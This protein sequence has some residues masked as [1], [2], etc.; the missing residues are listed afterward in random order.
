VTAPPQDLNAEESVLGAMLI[1]PGALGVV[2]EI[3]V[4]D[5]FYRHEHGAI[6][7]ACLELDGLGRPVDAL[8]VADYMDQCGTLDRGGGRARLHELAALVPA[9]ANAGHY[10]G[11]VREMATLRGLVRAGTEITRLGQ[12]RPGETIE[13]V[14]RAERI[15]AGV[16]R[17]S[18][19]EPEEMGPI[20]GRVWERAQEVAASGGRMV[21]IPSGFPDLDHLTLG[22][23]PGNLIVIAGRPSMGKSA[24]ALA[25]SS[26][27]ALHESTPTVVFSLEMSKL[28]LGQRLLCMEARI[29]SQ[30]LA[31]G[32]LNDGGWRRLSDASAVFGHAPLFIDDTC[33][34]VAEMRAKSRALARKAQ[35]GLIVVDYM[36][37]M[38]AGGTH[39]NRVQQISEISRSLKILAR[40]LGVPVIAL[41]QLSRAVEQR[42]DKRPML[43]DLRE[44]GSIEQDA[45][46]VIMVYRDE[47]YDPDSEHAGTAELILSKNRNGPTDT[48]RV[49]FVKRYAAFSPLQRTVVRPPS[50]AVLTG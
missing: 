24:L 27:N 34:A 28:E 14:E 21:G 11:I 9:T 25:I 38:A 40:D 6:F 15:V 43:S 29:N 20:A 19:G 47:Y 17:P 35:I 32:N 39:E 42:Q 48:V 33:Y 44:S 36:Q 2:S 31:T 45:D 26:H 46:M 50:H 13:L 10:A 12:D 4:A 23:Q 30:D 3:L 22:F 37:L 1:S 49:A 18:H 16:N 8:T 5:D 41:S 7:S